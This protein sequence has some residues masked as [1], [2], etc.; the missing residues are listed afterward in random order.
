MDTGEG[1]ARGAEERSCPAG[2]G[3]GRR[4]ARARRVPSQADTSRARREDDFRRALHHSTKHELEYFWRLYSQSGKMSTS[5]RGTLMQRVFNLLL[6]V[7]ETFS[8][9]GT[10]FCCKRVLMVYLETFSATCT[11]FCLQL[12]QELP[13]SFIQTRHSQLWTDLL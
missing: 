1:R 5:A 3:G 12:F 10:R 7:I 2:Q 4:G 11:R 13:L 8:A 6:L 9:T